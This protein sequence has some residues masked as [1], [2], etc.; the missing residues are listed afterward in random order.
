LLLPWIFGLILL[1]QST[2][3]SG[4]FEQPVKQDIQPLSKSIEKLNTQKD[5]SASDLNI[6]YQNKPIISIKRSDISVP[7]QD[8]PLANTE[9]LQQITDM[10]DK[11]VRIEATNAY[12]NEYGQLIPEK[13]GV[14]LNQTR[15][16]DQFYTYF[17]EG[18]PTSIDVP[19]R[20]IYPRVDSELLEN[21]RTKLIGHYITYFNSHNRERSHNITLATQAVNNQVV[22][23]GESFSFNHTVGKR[24]AAKGYLP[25]PIIVRGELSEGI[26]G[27]I[28][29]VSSTLFNAVDRSGLEIVQRF[30]HSKSVP[31][32]PP[33]RDATVSWYGPDFV[34]KNQYN[35]PILI[36]AKVHSGMMIVLIFSSDDIEYKSKQ[37]PSVHSRLPEEIQHTNHPY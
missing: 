12:L 32:V 19:L 26:G 21:I 9:R 24:T 33:K 17:Y 29:Q 16:N 20:T 1:V 4:D 27:G 37:V 5:Q 22:F 31:Y 25:A 10:I 23:P 2:T 3:Q 14:Q 15:F 35:Q 8:F 11:M 13:A 7:F 6:L 36:R 28:C 30:S 34:F 18:S